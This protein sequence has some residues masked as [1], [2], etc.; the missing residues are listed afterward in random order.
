MSC[1]SVQLF[2]WQHERGVSYWGGSS[3]S[4]EALYYDPLEVLIKKY[5]S[6]G[7]QGREL[8]WFSS[9]LTDQ[10]QVS[11]LMLGFPGAPSWVRYSY[12]NDLPSNMSIGSSRVYL[13]ADDTAIFVKGESIDVINT[14]LNTE[15]ASVSQ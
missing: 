11:Q 15:P 6:I 14:A 9:Y 2:A 13:Y 7:V 3:W 1:W 10:Y 4:L 12:I 8:D 5:I